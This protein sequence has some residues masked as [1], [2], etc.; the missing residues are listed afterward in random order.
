MGKYGEKIG[1]CQK[2]CSA[3][4]EAMQFT[5][6]QQIFKLCFPQ[7]TQSTRFTDFCKNGAKM[8]LKNYSKLTA[9]RCFLLLKIHSG[10]ETTMFP[11][12]LFQYYIIL[13]VQI[14][15]Q[16]C[17]LNVSCCN[18]NRLL[19]ICLEPVGKVT[20]SSLQQNCVT[21]GS[22]CVPIKYLLS[23]VSIHSLNNIFICHVVP[24][25]SCWSVSFLTFIQCPEENTAFL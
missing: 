2:L 20:F 22:N 10:R 3:S 11:G 15:F 13:T 24:T 23:P 8:D 21:L 17:K 1:Q 9:L 12:D 18:T 14:F 25:V 5:H 16:M 7:K 4:N 6:T 19:L